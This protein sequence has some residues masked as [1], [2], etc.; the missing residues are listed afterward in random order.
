M[1]SFGPSFKFI[2]EGGSHLISATNSIVLA[3]KPLLSLYFEGLTSQYYTAPPPFLFFQWLTP[4]FKQSY[5]QMTSLHY[6]I[7]IT[8]K[9]L[10]V[11][12]YCEWPWQQSM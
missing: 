7:I 5:R 8:G 9:N 4:V 1:N 6:I 12:R 11:G 10:E 3:A 2:K